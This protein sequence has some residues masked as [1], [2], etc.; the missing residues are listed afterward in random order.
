MENESSPNQD[1]DPSFSTEPGQDEH[2]AQTSDS[3]ANGATNELSNQTKHISKILPAIL[4]GILI[5]GCVFGI[6]LFPKLDLASLFDTEDQSYHTSDMPE[7]TLAAPEANQKTATDFVNFDQVFLS[8]EN[9]NTA[10]TATTIVKNR[11]FSPLSIKYA[12]AMLSDG[13][14][15]ETKTEID[16]ILKEYAPGVYPNN[17][18][19]SLANALFIRSDLTNTIK[20]SYKTTLADKY[21]ADIIPDSFAS[22]NPANDWVKEKTLGIIPEFFTSDNI[23]PGTAY[24]LANALAIDMNW[25]RELQCAEGG[26]IDCIEYDVDY[27]HEKYSDYVSTLSND[28][29]G[30][31]RN[32]TF[33]ETYENTPAVKIAI[34]ANRYDI[35]QDLGEENI[36]QTVQSAYNSW[37]AEVDANPERFE[38]SSSE[39]KL[40]KYMKELEEN[41]GRF[42]ASSDFSFAVTDT[43]KVFAK[44]LQEYDGETMEYVAIM[45]TTQNLTSFI[46]SLNESRLNTI[47]SSLRP[48]T[49][50]SFEEGVVT[51]LNGYIPLFNFEYDLPLTEILK[52]L[53]V[54]CAFDQAQADFSNMADPLTNENVYV[55]EALHKAKIEFSNDGIKAAAVTAITMSLEGM[56]DYE[57]EIFDYKFDVPIKEIDLTFDRPFL[58]L[59]RDKASGEIW[60]TGEVYNPAQGKTS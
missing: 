20:E 39:F 49:L 18:N 21:N 35:I 34:S 48:A 2:I 56:P 13:A 24:V 55:K 45:P 26:K 30:R 57:G 59:I 1:P 44:D 46:E 38:D 50:E 27:A 43:E 3:F 31:P 25:K 60:F 52:Q 40:K 4:I 8:L 11:I 19:R 47:L 58:F 6:V 16:S 22:P 54:R 14:N 51:K 23:N 10:E 9:A 37:K 7:V 17:A 32:I 53:G 29:W 12:L 5:I 36:R 15:G 41:Y 42:D 28:R 33:D